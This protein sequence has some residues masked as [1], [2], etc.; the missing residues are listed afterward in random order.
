MSVQDV[1]ISLLLLVMVMP[2]L[3]IINLVKEL[4]WYSGRV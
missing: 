4:L 3:L 1:L 2:K